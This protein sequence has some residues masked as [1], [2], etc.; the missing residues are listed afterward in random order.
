MSLLH[1][2]RVERR[3]TARAVMC[4]NVLLYGETEAGEKF[5]YWTRSVSVS[6][7][8]GVLLL[9]TQLGLG[10]VFQLVNEFSGRKAAAKIVA[11][12]SSRDGQVSASFEFTEGGEKFWGMTFPA[13]GARP[14][15][16]LHARPADAR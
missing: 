14:L 9:E 12:R 5:K 3:R 6:A 7:H 4:I 15:R 13:S 10:Q 2:R 1:F 11:L 16:R 8:G